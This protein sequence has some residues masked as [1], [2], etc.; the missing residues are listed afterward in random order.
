MELS[1]LLGQNFLCYD[2]KGEV[3]SQ[4]HGYLSI[5][6]KELRKLEK[7]APTLPAKAKNRWYV[8][9]LSS[10]GSKEITKPL[11]LLQEEFRIKFFRKTKSY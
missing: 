8:P 10:A 2:G 4:I 6:Y 11:S 3:P 5:N 1:V 9:G 7:D